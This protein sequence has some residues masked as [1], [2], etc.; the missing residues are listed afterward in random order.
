MSSPAVAHLL[1]EMKRLRAQYSQVDPES[2][3]SDMA[4][5]QRLLQRP[6]CQDVSGTMSSTPPAPASRALQLRRL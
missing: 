3:I 1:S 5:G 2:K 6:H 4:W